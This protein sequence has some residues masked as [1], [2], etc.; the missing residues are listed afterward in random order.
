MNTD[1]KIEYFEKSLAR[2]LKITLEHDVLFRD[3]EIT[4]KI[5]LH[6][7][8]PPADTP[9][10]CE[11]CSSDEAHAGARICVGCAHDIW[12]NDDPDVMFWDDA[13]FIEAVHGTGYTYSIDTDD[14]DP[15]DDDPIG[16]GDDDEHEEIISGECPECGGTLYT[17]N[18][19]SEQCI[20]CGAKWINTD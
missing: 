12:L 1:K 2:A 19:I 7:P 14:D 18:G 16:Q 11:N 15:D 13:C 10:M 5:T 17:N 8:T 6:P 3:A 4:V 9:K 20:E